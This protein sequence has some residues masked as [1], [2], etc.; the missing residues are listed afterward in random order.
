MNEILRSTTVERKNKTLYLEGASEIE[1]CNKG[2]PCK[3]KDIPLEY[4]ES[5]SFT[6]PIF[7]AK[8]ITLYEIN[9]ETDNSL[10]NQLIVIRTIHKIKK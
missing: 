8:D 9:F 1:F 6:T 4:G 3:I 5:I 7:G 2:N 10:D